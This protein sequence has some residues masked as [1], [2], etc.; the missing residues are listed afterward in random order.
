MWSRVATSSIPSTGPP[1]A[2]ECSNLKSA[3][4]YPG[5]VALKIAK[6]CEQISSYTF[7]QDCKTF[8]CQ[9][10]YLGG[11]S[12]SSLVVF[13]HCS[14]ERRIALNAEDENFKKL[15]RFFFF[16][17]PNLWFSLQTQWTFHQGC[18]GNQ[19]HQ[20]CVCFLTAFIAVRDGKKKPLCFKKRKKNERKNIWRFSGVPW[21]CC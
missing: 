14:N 12:C 9:V 8:L 2:V 20:K 15:Q 7:T 21:Q 6:E 13:S 17:V 3:R 10:V 18:A 1:I 11:G 5:T 4:E 19:A 16:K